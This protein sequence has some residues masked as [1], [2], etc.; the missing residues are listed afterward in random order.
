MPIKYQ[1]NELLISTT[2]SDELLSVFT[3]SK[4]S[5]FKCSEAKLYDELC[6]SIYSHS[7]GVLVYLTTFP[8]IAVH[9]YS[10]L[11]ND[12]KVNEELYYARVVE[13]LESQHSIGNVK[14]KYSWQQDLRIAQ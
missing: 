3:G 1:P 6:K 8:H 14:P 11:K 2:K 9:L 10:M 13:V 7:C 5:H 4:K 12:I